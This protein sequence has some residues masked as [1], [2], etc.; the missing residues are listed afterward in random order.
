MLHTCMR[1]VF[2]GCCMLFFRTFMDNYLRRRLT[3]HILVWLSN[4]AIETS[5]NSNATFPSAVI[6]VQVQCFQLREATFV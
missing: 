2:T 4:R 3:L 1:I 5:P 6:I